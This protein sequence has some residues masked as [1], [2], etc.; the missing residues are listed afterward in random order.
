[1][2]KRYVLTRNPFWGAAWFLLLV[3][4]PYLFF[5]SMV[6]KG[7]TT[8]LWPYMQADVQQLGWNANTISTDVTQVTSDRNGNPTD[9][10]YVVRGAKTVSPGLQWQDQGKPSLP[11]GYWRRRNHAHGLNCPEKLT[12]LMVMPQVVQ[13]AKLNWVDSSSGKP[14]QASILIWRQKPG[15]LPTPGKFVFCVESYRR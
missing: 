3:S 14:K 1:M 8:R 9:A 10:L 5:A 4:G 15:T 6:P 11:K 12:A 13:T 2:S 7:T